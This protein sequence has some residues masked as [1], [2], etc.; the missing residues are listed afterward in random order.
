MVC[1][2]TDVENESIWLSSTELRKLRW[3]QRRGNK[4][5]IRL[6]TSHWAGT[7]GFAEVGDGASRGPLPLERSTRPLQVWR[8]DRF[9]FLLLEKAEKPQAEF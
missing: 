7:E 5:S 3:G 6:G 9:D 1:Y 8:T 2:S 4:Y